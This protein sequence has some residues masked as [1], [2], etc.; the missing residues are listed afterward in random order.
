MHPKRPRQP[1]RR[2]AALPHIEDLPG[3]AAI[4][5]ALGEIGEPCSLKT[6][7]MRLDVARGAPRE[8][9][10]RRVLAMVRDGQLIQN[11][12]GLFG[13]AERMELIPGRVLAHRDGYAFVRPEAGG[14][15]IY[16]APREARRTL[17][18]DRVLVRIAGFDRRER[19]YG[20]LIEV[21]E[22]AHEQ[23]VGRYFSDRNFGFVVPDNRHLNQDVLIPPG[24]AGAA[25]D[26]Q[27]VVAAIE[28]QPDRHSQPVGRVTEILGEHMA[29]GMEIE[30]AVR[31]Y[32]LPCE[33][34][35]AVAAAAAAVPETP[36]AAE[37]ARRRDLRA[38]PLVTIDGADARDFDDAVFARRT[39]KGFTLTV[40]IADV[41][42]YVTPGSALDEEA[43]RRGTSVYFPDRVIPMLPEA[44][45]NGICSLVPDAERLALVCEMNI[46]LDGEV[47]RA[48]FYE[49]VI[50][51]HA[52]LIYTDVQ[53]WHEGE[54]ATLRGVDAEVARSL[55][56]LYELYAVLRDA[57]EQRGALDIDSV[58]PRFH[59]DELGKIASVEA[60]RRVD[61]HRLIE[62]CMIAA[63]V[64]A[65][66]HLI[67]HRRAALYRVHDMPDDDRVEDLGRFLRELGL[68]FRHGAAVDA[69]DFAA[70]LGAARERTDRRLIETVVLRSLKL[71][72]YS[73]Q[74][75]GHFGLSLDAYTHFT[76]PIR[77]YP[78]LVVH[79]ALK[80]RLGSGEALADN[81][82]PEL[83]EHCSM[84]ERRA[85]EAT[86]DAVA[87]LKCEFM[88]DKVGE[89]F[90][91]IVSGVAEFGVFV[92]LDD[93]FVEGL[94]HVSELPGDYYQYDAAG[95]VLRG[96]AHHREFRIGLAIAVRV[97]RVDLDERK[98][99]FVLAEP[100][101][102]G[103]RKRRRR[104]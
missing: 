104:R 32:N 78:D 8:A 83:A 18:G 71:A 19:P 97:A 22:R 41:A 30:I 76:S 27:I 80:A 46:G 88:L 2:G 89:V 56:A 98:I 5:E 13:L 90:P 65:A 3:R 66:R 82:M 35:D 102:D 101:V 60:T 38:L 59:Y 40:A 42:H 70:V 55:R 51:S 6:L 25:R 77:R 79:R 52:R 11:R 94:V 75:T 95:H 1:R 43:L 62:E 54:M 23:V 14:D 67:R 103:G 36:T 64:A 93:I 10:E 68:R 72:V 28:Q 49:A 26:G 85:D 12:S 29:P 87:W 63:N 100:A 50:R 74:N 61:A 44:L 69:R 7:A 91:G 45:S 15:D 17:H 9:L 84:C 99:D 4:A 39:A 58:E 57:R 37:I 31:S 96:R 47:R 34:P 16:L 24:A 86:R 20:N 21:L 53:R 48:R 92:E 73:A 33:W 81:G